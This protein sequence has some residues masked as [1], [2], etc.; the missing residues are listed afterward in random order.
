MNTDLDRTD[1]R[2]HVERDEPSHDPCN[3]ARK[4]QRH[5]IEGRR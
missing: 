3:L 5:E 2:S 4:S 1:T